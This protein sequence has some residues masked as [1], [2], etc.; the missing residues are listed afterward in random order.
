MQ[1]GLFGGARTKR[2][3]GLDDS[4]GCGSGTSRAVDCETNNAVSRRRYDVGAC[5]E[6][7]IAGFT[8]AARQAL[9][10]YRGDFLEEIYDNWVEEPRAYYQNLYFATLK[11]L[12]YCRCF[13][14]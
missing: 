2:S 14:E 12:T 6:G 11:D 1:F 13:D 3:I 5:C 9:E 10:L 7:D 8:T 4:Q